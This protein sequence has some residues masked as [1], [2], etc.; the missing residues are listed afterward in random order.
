MA[1]SCYGVDD[2]GG[3]MKL[4]RFMFIIVPIFV[5]SQDVRDATFVQKDYDWLVENR[6][7]CVLEIRENEINF[8]EQW[9]RFPA[10]GVQMSSREDAR[11]PIEALQPPFWAEV[12]FYGRDNRVFIRSIRFLMHMTYDEKGHTIGEYRN[13]E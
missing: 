2:K 12:S 10:T 8:E 6:Q 13:K 9:M 5:G 1:A 11:I 3:E 7:G 4:M